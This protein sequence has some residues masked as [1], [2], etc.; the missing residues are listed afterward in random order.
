M[1]DF[2]LFRK[3]FGER[4]ATSETKLLGWSA[5]TEKFEGELPKARGNFIKVP[6]Q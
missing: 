3:V 5:F 6:L 1:I 2:R 4:G